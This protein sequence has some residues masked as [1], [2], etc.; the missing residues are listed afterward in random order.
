MVSVAYV[1]Q[2]RV[3]RSA[4][5]G[6]ALKALLDFFKYFSSISTVIR[7]GKCMY[8]LHLSFSIS[9]SSY[10]PSALMVRCGDWNRY[11]NSEHKKHQDREV[12]YISNHPR[13]SGIKD[14]YNDMTLLHLKE[15]FILD[16]HIDTICLPK[17]INDR[18]NN[19][20]KSDCIVMGWGKEKESST[21]PQ[22]SLKQVALS[23]VDNNQ[24]QDLFRKTERLGSTF[25]LDE[26]FLCAGGKKNADACSG[27]GGGP[28]V[29]AKKNDKER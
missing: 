15:E 8:N 11:S 7:Q 27:D 1:D 18:E 14:V 20:N 10:P 13:F 22:N 16:S 4:S 23:I 28:L 19:Y 17:F 29:C 3:G 25:V 2:M 24:C 6:K 12:Q 5:T 26:S 9:F 21:K